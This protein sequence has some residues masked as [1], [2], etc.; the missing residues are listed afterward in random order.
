MGTVSEAL[1]IELRLAIGGAAILGDEIPASGPYRLF[2]ARSGNEPEGVPSERI[3][4]L[5]SRPPEGPTVGGMLD[6][7]ACLR[8]I[9]HPA[10]LAPLAVGQVADRTWVIESRPLLPPLTWQVRDNGPL[11]VSEVVLMFRE[12]AR[13]LAMMHRHN[14][15]HGMVKP[16]VVFVRGEVSRLGGLGLGQEGTVEDD[17]HQLGRV[18]WFALT[19]FRQKPG[20]RSPRI[21]RP[22][23]PPALDRV[24]GALLAPERATLRLDSAEAV[25]AA[26]D[27]VPARAGSPLAMLIDG[28]ER[29]ARSPD[30]HRNLAIL[31]VV[32]VLALIVLWFF[33][34]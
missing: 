16:E 5:H 21:I 31:A 9:G 28:A 29:G 20:D 27:H 18:C 23:I 14:L 7:M 30:T 11:P 2:N 26:L 10:I 24:I 8:A 34:R 1:L 15:R 19:G 25:L 12:M 6:R 33:G 13:A 4:V 22:Q 3:V 32:S 17:L